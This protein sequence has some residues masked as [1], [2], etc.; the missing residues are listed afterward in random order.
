MLRQRLRRSRLPRLLTCQ[1]VTHIRYRPRRVDQQN[2]SMCAVR[3]KSHRVERRTKTNASVQT[4]CDSR[5]SKDPDDSVNSDDPSSSKNVH[6]DRVIY[7]GHSLNLSEFATT[8][9]SKDTSGIELGA[10]S[11]PAQ[12]FAP[13]SAVFAGGG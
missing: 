9:E 12:V 6:C 8:S 4:F 10:P 11:A 5:S 2:T 7:I 1:L 13:P 3:D